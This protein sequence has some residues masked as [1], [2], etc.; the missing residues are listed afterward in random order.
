MK[1]AVK[2]SKKI[3]VG[4]IVKTI[5]FMISIPLLLIACIISYKAVKYPDK[6]PD[7]FGVK[8]MIVL[9]G[10]ME[11]KIHTGDLVFVRM[12]DPNSLNVN[13]IIAFR[14]EENK[15]T[16]HRIVKKIEDNGEILFRTKGDNNSSEDADL[17]QSSKVE[18]I[19]IARIGM[20]GSFLMFMQQPIG[21]AIIL[22]TILVVGLICL[23]VMNKIEER[24]LS[25]ED[26]KYQ[27]E[28]EEFKRRKQEEKKL[29]DRE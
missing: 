29:R 13:D 27:Q 8:P 16:T 11:S 24:K 20:I 2:S 9:S 3:S 10:S 21:L 15:V 7:V 18:G 17:V 22:L 25:K 19:Y 1:K 5:F 26:K 12:I 23:Q 4:I 6:I 28:F 14:N